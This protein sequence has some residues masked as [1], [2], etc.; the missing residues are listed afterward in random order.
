MDGIVWSVATHEFT[1]GFTG[2]SVFDF[3]GDGPVELVYADECWARVFDG[4]TGAVKFS[5]PHESGTVA[6]YPVVA[7]VDGD[8]FTEI[9]V[10]NH[11]YPEGACPAQ[12][13]LMPASVREPGRSYA[14][15]TVYRDRT[16]R[17]APSRPLWT[18]H[19]EHYSQRNDDGT[20]PTVELPSWESHNS[21][22]QAHPPQGVEAYFIPDLTVGGLEAPACDS[23]AREQPLAARVCNRG[24]LPAAAGVAVSFRLDSPDGAELC[25][26]ATTGVLQGGD[27]EDVGCTWSGVPLE[28]THAVF[29]VVDPDDGEGVVEC[30]EDNNLATD[31]VRC[32]PP[33]R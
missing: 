19:T 3:E 11:P 31:E 8:F 4:A 24:T 15:I 6:E 27:C 26:A 2:S 33:I 7:D 21:Y 1:S 9:V 20:V 22:R 18:Q 25:A 32:P 30:H 12:D 13:P 28:E 29:A 23:E 14:G 10:P 16:D 5:A 17:W